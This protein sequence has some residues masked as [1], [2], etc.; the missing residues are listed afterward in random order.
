M[1]LFDTLKFVLLSL[2]FIGFISCS[3]DDDLDDD[4]ESVPPVEENI[5]ST[6]SINDLNKSGRISIELGEDN[7]VRIRVDLDIPTST[8]NTVKIYDGHFDGTD[9]TA[10]AYLTLNPIA[11]G[12]TS[13]VTEVTQS[14]NGSEVS[15]EDLISADRHLRVL[16]ALVYL[17]LLMY[18]QI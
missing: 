14:D 13:S 12:E 16:T 9:I 2:F 5:F 15:Y 10:E 4:G 3:H 1:K 7:K 18:L 11:S 6:Y 17:Y 8:E